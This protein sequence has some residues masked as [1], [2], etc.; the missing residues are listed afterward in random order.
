[1]ISDVLKLIVC[2]FEN[3]GTTLVST[4]C[5]Q[6][7]RL[8]SG[9]ECGFLLGDTPRDF[10]TIQPYCNYFKE[11]WEVH[12]NQV[13]YMCDTDEW[14]ECYR[15][16][17]EISPV[18]QDKSTMML[19]KTPGYMRDLDRVLAK[20][21]Q[22]PCVVIVRDPRALMVSWAKRTGFET[23]PE[24]WLEHHLPTFCTR[25]VEYA[26]GY[27][28]AMQRFP[29]RL[30][31]IQFEHLCTDP[32]GV[33]SAL[34]D[35]AGLTFDGAYTSF[36]TSYGVHGNNV[37]RHFLFPYRGYFS[38]ETCATILQ[39]TER[40]AQWHFTESA[41]RSPSESS[42]SSSEAAVRATTLRRRDASSRE[43]A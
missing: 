16:A 36:S 43:I 1:M 8:D 3:S 23:S 19:D 26:N 21:P 42:P 28:R 18:I 33:F 25:Y 24:S 41:D 15:R 27:R 37:S 7:P 4:V 2:G 13:A 40:Y 35:F 9:F 14:G 22:I 20:V 10:P 6:H 12:D 11:R 32:V 29:D 31:L 17:R 38:H 34:F 39:R 30:M 5:C